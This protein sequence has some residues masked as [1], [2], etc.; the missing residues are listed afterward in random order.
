MVPRDADNGHRAKVPENRFIITLSGQ[1]DKLINGSHR[2]AVRTREL[3]DCVRPPDWPAPLRGANQSF[4]LTFCPVN[5]AS[6]AHCQG[7]KSV[8][9]VLSVNIGIRI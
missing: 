3:P 9:S 7:K 4:D 8:N 6:H 2:F 5:R 1:N